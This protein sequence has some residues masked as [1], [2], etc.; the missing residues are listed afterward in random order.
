[1][2]F[3]VQ[4]ERSAVSMVVGAVSVHIPPIQRARIAANSIPSVI[5]LIHHLAKCVTVLTPI[6]KETNNGGVKL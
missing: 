5:L 4:E 1:M 3:N 6:A 2:T